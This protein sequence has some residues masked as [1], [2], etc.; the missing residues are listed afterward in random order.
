MQSL[1]PFAKPNL[2]LQEQVDHAS[3]AEVEALKRA[4][5]IAFEKTSKTDNY[6]WIRDRDKLLIAVLWASGSRI[7]DALGMTKDKISYVDHSITFLVHKRKSKKKN[8][9]GKFW[10]TITIDNFTISEIA[11]YTNKWD[12]KGL[13]FPASLKGT[14]SLTRQAVAIKLVKYGAIAG[15]RHIHCHMMRHGIAMHLQS[16]GVPAEAIT[17]HL[18]HSSTS[19]TISTY[20][21]MSASQEKAILENINVKFR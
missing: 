4:C 16:Q 17:H 19:V 21:R 20:A 14:K 8:T 5:D 13:L 2:L 11:D 9:D 7:S 15:L 10:H 18:A 12:M 6:E 3:L 1:V